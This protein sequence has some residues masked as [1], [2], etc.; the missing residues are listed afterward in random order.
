MKMKNESNL[1]TTGYIAFKE[2]SD[3]GPIGIGSSPEKA[4]A[5]VLQ[6][7]DQDTIVDDELTVERGP[8]NGWI[9]IPAT[10][11]LIAEFRDGYDGYF[12]VV[13]GIAIFDEFFDDYEK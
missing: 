8:T 10:A 13:D 9:C 3:Y 7:I 6:D 1:V 5:N 12:S 4:W 2:F 11:R